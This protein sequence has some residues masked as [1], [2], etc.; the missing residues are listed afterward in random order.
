VR[1]FNIGSIAHITGGGITD[2]LPRVVPKGYKAVVHR[3]S[4]E[5]PPIFT[6]LKEKGNIPE[7]EMLRTFN[8]GIGMVIVV[9]TKETE[10]I[11]GRLNSLGQKA[12]V[13]GEIEKA[14]REQGSIEFV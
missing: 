11:L 1:D 13:I 8:N 3:G 14:D 12:F 2:N 9:R 10:D 5:I 4:W 6:F 7:D